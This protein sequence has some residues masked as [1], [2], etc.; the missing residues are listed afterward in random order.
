[1]TVAEVKESETDLK[2]KAAGLEDG[3]SV[4]ESEN[5]G[6][7]KMEKGEKWILTQS[8]QAPQQIDTSS[9][10]RFLYF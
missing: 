9:V 7:W 6:I 1:M 2:S 8:I 5:S 10:I 4:N 3:K